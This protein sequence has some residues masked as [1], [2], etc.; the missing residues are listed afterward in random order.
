MKF[1]KYNVSDG[2]NKARVH[3]SLD[4]RIDGRKCVTIYAKD[5]INKLHEIPLIP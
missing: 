5:Y 1:N 4:N 3:Y 2:Q